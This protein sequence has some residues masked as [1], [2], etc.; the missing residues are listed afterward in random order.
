MLVERYAAR[1]AELRDVLK[2]DRAPRRRGRARQAREAS[3][4]VNPNRIRSRCMLTG[5][6][7]AIYRKFG[8][9]G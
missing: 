3:A 2:H 8:V 6:P 5:R 7:R 4:D 1:R 9:R